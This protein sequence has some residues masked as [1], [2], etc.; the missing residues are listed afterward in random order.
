LKEAMKGDILPRR[1]FSGVALTGM[2]IM[3]FILFFL[4]RESPFRSSGGR[5]VGHPC[6]KEWYP[7]YEPPEF[8]ISP[9][10]PARFR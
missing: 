6:R 1:S 5:A 10:S 8:G 3:I 9:W 4:A 2:T 7:T